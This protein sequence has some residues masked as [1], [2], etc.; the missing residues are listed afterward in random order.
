MNCTVGEIMTF[1]LGSGEELVAK[2]IGTTDGE[3]TVSNPVSVAPSHQGIG[4]INSLFTAETKNEVRININ[5]IMMYA[6]TEEGVKNK[7]IEA[8]TG[9]TIANKKLILG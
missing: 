3:I 1:K 7:Y 2:Y 9:I 5:S 8:T 6:V 4:L